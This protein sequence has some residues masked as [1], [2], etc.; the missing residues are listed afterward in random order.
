MPYTKLSELPDYIQKK[1]K[2][3]QER[4]LAAFNAAYSKGEAY[5][6]KVANAAIK[7][8]AGLH[9][10]VNI[11]NV[12][13]VKDILTELIADIEA[14]LEKAEVGIKG[15][16]GSPIVRQFLREVKGKVKNMMASIKETGLRE[17]A[18]KIV[19]KLDE[20]DKDGSF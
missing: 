14:F 3:L 18:E 6:F 9:N 7:E 8:S 15:K 4:W 12:T 20:A 1:P 10:A 2:K 13:N 11:K 5:A 17:A 19:A 16:I